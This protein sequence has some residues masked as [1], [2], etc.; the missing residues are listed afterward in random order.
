ME[1]P[2]PQLSDFLIQ[3]RKFI[4]QRA[5]LPQDYRLHYDSSNMDHHCAPTSVPRTSGRRRCSTQSIGIPM[6][7]L[8]RPTVSTNYTSLRCCTKYY[9]QIITYIEV[10]HNAN[11][12]RVAMPRRR[13]EITS[14]DA[15]EHLERR[16]ERIR[17]LY[18]RRN[19]RYYAPLQR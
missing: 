5:L 3:Q 10:T 1:H 12:A 4:S 2:T 6:Q 19:V 16:G 13:T 17:L 7:R 8:S 18:Y 11:A 14:S 15:P 9:R